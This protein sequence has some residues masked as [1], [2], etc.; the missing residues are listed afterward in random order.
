M[1]PASFAII[2]YIVFLLTQ[3]CQDVLAAHEPVFDDTRVA[4]E[5][6]SPSDCD[7][8]DAGDDC[9]PFCICSCRTVPAGEYSISLIPEPEIFA[10]IVRRNPIDYTNPQAKSFASIVWQPPKH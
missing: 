7:E 9:S 10:P 3:P 2:V 4:T 6:S 1:R 5:M 8:G